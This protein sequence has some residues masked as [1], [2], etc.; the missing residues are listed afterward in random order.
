MKDSN[1][2]TRV[3]GTQAATIQKLNHIIEVLETRLAIEESRRKALEGAPWCLMFY[4][5]FWGFMGYY[6]AAAFSAWW[7]GRT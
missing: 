4:G 3:I 6:A 2:E 7:T 1:Y 5:T